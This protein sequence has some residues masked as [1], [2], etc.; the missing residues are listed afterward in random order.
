MMFGIES[1]L[2]NQRLITIVLASLFISS[3]LILSTSNNAFAS[4]SQ[5]GSCSNEY[6]G[7]IT[8]A[9]ITVGGQPYYPLKNSVSFQLAND[10]QYTLSFTIHTPS[11]D[12]QG[13]S[14]PGT[15]WYRT[16]YQGFGNG[17]CQSG[18]GPNQ[19]FI[20]SGNFGHSD[21]NAP[22]GSFTDEWS[23][24]VTGFSYTINWVN[25]S[26]QNLQATAGNSQINLTWSA[27][28][29]NDIYPP[30]N[31][32]IYRSTSS[33]TETVLTTLGN[34]NSYTDTPV[35]NGQAYYYYVTAGNPYGDSPASNEVSATPSNGSS[36]TAPQ[37]PTGLKAT[38][39]SPSQINLI[40]T[41]PTNNGGSAITGYQIQ[42]SSDGGLS[43]P[44]LVS[45]TN[46]AV[47]TYS[48]TGLSP[49]I[50]Y[51]YRVSAINSVGGGAPS[52][53][54]SATTPSI[55]LDAS[56][57]DCCYGDIQVIYSV[58]NPIQGV[59][60]AQL[61]IYAPNGTLVINQAGPLTYDQD[62]YSIKR[63]EGKGNYSV[64][65]T[66]DNS[67]TAKISLPSL[68]NSDP[69]VDF[70]IV[71]ERSD[72]SVGINGRIENGLAAEQVSIA[73]LDPNKSTTATYTV[74]TSTHAIYEIEIN[75]TTA[76]QVFPQS[77]TYTIVVT[78]IPT[79]VQG[80]TVLTYTIPPTSLTA[81]QNGNWNDPAT[82]G[83][84]SP[85]ITINSGDT[86]TIPAGIT[87]T[88]PSS[89]AISNTG[90]ITNFGTISN[91]GTLRNLGYFGNGGTITNNSGS[92]ISNYGTINSY[93][94]VSNSGTITNNSGGTITN[95]S[96]GKLN[97]LAGGLISNSGIISNTSIIINNVY[98]N[99]SDAKII[100]TG[101]I[102]G[103]GKIL[104]TPYFNRG[105]ITNT[106]TITDPVTIPNTTLSSNYTPSFPL[107]VPSGVTF[108]IPS[109]QTLT[110]NSGIS[111]SNLGTII[112]AGTIS[113]S[114]TISGTGTIKSALTSITNTGT[115]TD[116]VTIPNTTLSSS[117]AVSFP[118]NVPSGVTLAINSGVTLTINSGASISSSGYL[119][120]LGTI[121]NSGAL[122]NSGYLGNGGTITINSGGTITN[123]GI[124]NSYGTI[125]NSGT[126]T[127]NSSGTIK[128]YSGGKINNLS[129][130][131]ISNSG[132]I[133][134][135]S[136]IIN[137]VY[138]NSSDAKIINSG[139]IS[140]TG[141]ILST[142]YFN[143]SS[144]TNTGT[145]SD[146]V[147]IPNTTL[148]SSYTPSFPL[149]V[150]SGVTFTIPS[151]QTLTIN[152]GISISNL[153]T[154]INAGTISNSGTISG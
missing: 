152:S 122:N 35:I 126:V 98:N 111:I 146:P 70:G 69:V 21:S 3:L 51:G 108:T 109:G 83:G 12:L 151:G 39:V 101:T 43:W 87:V 115:I 15:V 7:P 60:Q 148:S 64:I 140:G 141:K 65:A 6:D 143:R 153:G 95:Y 117:Y 28:S 118:V 74:T 78:H 26:P 145:I 20:I 17:V 73:I 31:Y 89:V 18:A 46:S 120:N 100:N 45:N 59:D 44:T 103:T 129:G 105:S 116:P 10:K 75:S 97:N 11:Q 92:A 81:T 22:A 54:A 52:N 93:G 50:N 19:D 23:T 124:I 4:G 48:D 27:P 57:E 34:V 128:N 125:S 96:G 71:E 37:P 91:S 142:P 139:T 104:S 76:K 66:Y 114:G 133:N 79:G 107:I 41:A 94:T 33:G 36:S 77:G 9:T 16:N 58:Q 56:F 38:T 137:N 134:N 42:R 135:T 119:K 113:N 67:L 147:T 1:R 47:T 49:G 14:L 85:P 154:I 110:V 63:A 29:N 131:T 40:W 90:T 82:W 138:N 8:N 62:A 53:S 5:P 86:V 127:N 30:T 112:N 136:T 102:S 61:Q 72:G 88:I 68:I 2:P 130:G 144:I 80:K 123:S 25:A 32:K 150:P 121:S 84:A 132:T 24:T 149:I 55:S 106:G 13:N 99:S